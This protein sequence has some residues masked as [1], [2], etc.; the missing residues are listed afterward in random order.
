MVRLLQSFGLGQTNLRRGGGGL[1]GGHLSL[2]VLHDP[3][4]TRALA[5]QRHA[6]SLQLRLLLEDKL[7][8][9]HQPREGRV[10]EGVVVL[11][12]IRL[13]HNRERHSNDGAVVVVV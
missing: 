5:V 2:Q 8:L 6:P 10:R 9:L 7:F 12:A 3:T 11:V 13:G 4:L 1:G